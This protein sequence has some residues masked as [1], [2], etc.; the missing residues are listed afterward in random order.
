[1]SLRDSAIVAY[2]ETKVMD[3]SDRDVWVLSGEILESLL[4]KTGFEKAEIDGL[5]MA[6]L[7]ATGAGNMF[8]AQ[9]TADQLGLEIDFCEQVH[10]GGCSA[11]GSVARAAAAIDAG[12]CE[13]AFL[14]FADTGVLE[15]NRGE[16]R[17]YRREWTDPYGLMGPPGS[18]GLLTRAYEAQYGLDYRM[19]GKLAVTQRNHALMNENACEKLRVPI[20]IDDYLNS[21]M[22][23]DPIRLLDCVMPADGAAGLIVTSKKRAKEK[24]LDKCVIPLGYAERTNFLGGENF[25]DVTRSGH[26]VA[27]RKALS[28]AG[29]GIKDIASFHP[30]DEFIIAI[31]MQFEA[32]G[33]CKPG[34][35]V[36]FIREHD[37]AY[38]GD[39]PL[40]TGGGQISAGQAAC[41]SHNLIE[42]VRQLMGEAGERQVKNTDNA[43]VTGIGWINYGRNWGTS[44]ALVLVPNA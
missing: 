15:H 13:T 4:D 39:L 9:T 43:L 10:T 37:F 41:S 12:L 34:Q 28:R 6:G 21:R 36:T 19:L 25:V 3:K 14:L 20:T 24:G 22:I 26:E 17:T 11:A 35:G 1:M 23:A 2:A 38:N 18:F 31:M 30:Y 5:V 7:T 27:G 29:L 33:F 40:N 8:W 32:F 42:A 44:A 16:E